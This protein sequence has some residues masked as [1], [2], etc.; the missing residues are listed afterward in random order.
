M[1][2][3]L[4]RDVKVAISTESASVVDINSN[5]A[6]GSSTSVV[7][8]CIE[9]LTSS[10]ADVFDG[11]SNYNPFTDVTGV[12]LTLGKVD[13][14]IAYMGQRTALKAEIKNETTVVITKKKLNKFWDHVFMDARY[15]SDGSALIDG[16]S[17]PTVKHGYRLYIALKDDGSSEVISIP[18]MTFTEHS[19]SLNVDGTTEETLTFMGHVEPFINTDVIQTAS[20]SS[21]L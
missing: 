17:Q 7:T 16:L 14:D 12:E 11:D 18:N 13:E 8:D 21:T 4:G 9:K 10:A 20:S 19:V 5:A 2:Y 15:G 1:V 3:F 6:R